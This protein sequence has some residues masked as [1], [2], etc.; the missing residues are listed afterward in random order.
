[1]PVSGRNCS[2]IFKNILPGFAGSAVSTLEITVNE[3]TALREMIRNNYSGRLVKVTGPEQ[4]KRV[5]G[6]SC[7]YLPVGIL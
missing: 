4:C 3:Y 5:K 2:A 6:N 7:Q 1:V